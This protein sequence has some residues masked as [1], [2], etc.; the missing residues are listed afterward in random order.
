ML[1][2]TYS[3][4]KRAREGGSI[5]IY[6]YDELPLKIRIQTIHIFLGA[7]GPYY[8]NGNYCEATKIYDYVV[9]EMRREVG[10]HKLAG[11]YRTTQDELFNWLENTGSVDY[12][13]DAA[14]Y[15]LKCIDNLI[16]HRREYFR[17]ATLSPDAAIAEFNGRMLEAAVGYQYVSGEILR[18][19]SQHL[20]TEVVLPALSLLSDPR[21]ASADQEYRSAH[22]AY[23][24]GELEDCIVDC[25][26][27]FES[28]LKIIGAARNWPIKET[29]P[30]SRLIQA[31]VD[32]GFIAAY[33]SAS[34]N[35]LKGLMESSTPTIRNKEGG[36]G[37][38][39]QI[40]NVSNELAALQLHQTAAMIVYLVSLDQSTDARLSP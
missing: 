8:H 7:I 9:A 33:H 29:D 31:A 11:N 35:H 27:S 18:I 13:L 3:R 15:C 6:S 1:P 20:H 39:I 4:R 12:W 21:F 17:G 2:Q 28:V 37:A 14:E 40:R 26:K 5:D 23:R 38:G 34:L 36:H 10:V 16:R 30:A 19:D 22:E 32:A 24:K 25:A